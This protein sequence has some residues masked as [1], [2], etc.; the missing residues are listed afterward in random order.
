MITTVHIG[1]TE[2]LPSIDAIT[3]H[4]STCDTCQRKLLE[5][6]DLAKR[7]AAL[8]RSG[9]KDWKE[10][11]RY[12]HVTTDKPASIRILSPAP[13]GRCSPA[14]ILNSSREGLKLSVPEFLH[15]GA[16]IQIYAAATTAFGEV[17]YCQPMSSAFHAGIQIRDSFPAPLDGSLESKR[18]DQ[19]NAVSVDAE[20]RIAGT[21]D[22]RPVTI[23]D[24]SKSGLRLRT[25]VT[26]PS[27]TQVEILYGNASISGE[28]RY[29]REVGLA[30][31]NLGINVHSVTCQWLERPKR[32]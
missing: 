25:K 6:L 4:L 23:L 16:T 30:E 32:R 28:T 15:P 22:L 11:R 19:R 29:S 1:A 21:E 8:T 14:R 3:S 5:S 17:R 10:K 7:V 27:G 12:E 13:S 20:M 24:V 2:N 26:F 31:F 18:K 9:A